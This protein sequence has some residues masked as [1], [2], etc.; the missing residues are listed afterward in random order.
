MEGDI[1][2]VGDCHHQAGQQYAINGSINL[3]PV[4]ERDDDAPRDDEAEPGDGDIHEE[5]VVR[6]G[7]DTEAQTANTSQVR[8]V[9]AGFSHA[10]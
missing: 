6:E 3:N 5:G 7:P 10:C 2:A 8:R 4:D 9:I 1:Q